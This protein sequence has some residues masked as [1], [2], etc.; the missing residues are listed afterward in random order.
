MNTTNHSFH[1]GIH[2]TLI[3]HC[4]EQ[5]QIPIPLLTD[6]ITQQPKH[7][8][9]AM[10]QLLHVANR[11]CLDPLIEEVTLMDDEEQ[12]LRPYITL[13]GWMRILNEQ[14]HYCGIQF[15][16]STELIDGIP[17]YMECTIYRDDRVL[18]IMIKEYY[19][20]IKTEHAV[21][22]HLPRRMMRHRALQ[23]CVRLAFG[24][25]CPER[26]YLK[27]SNTAK[28]I[29]DPASGSPYRKTEPMINPS[30]PK[31]EILKKL[32][33]DQSQPNQARP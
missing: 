18:P 31:T 11:Y 20:E 23:Q 1:P 29:S 7:H 15:R 32:L 9:L 4:A 17:S 12:F 30:H 8:Q 21:W 19:Q 26:S 28:F 2:Q 25:S 24:I 33:K 13:D 10:N 6:W 5:L 27:P 3:D 16:E 22:E 14:T